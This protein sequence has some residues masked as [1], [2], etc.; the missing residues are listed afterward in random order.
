MPLNGPYPHMG[1]GLG[2]Q[3]FEQWNDN[4]CRIWQDI[5]SAL[6]DGL[7][8]IDV[9]ILAATLNRNPEVSA[10]LTDVS[11]NQYATL[12]RRLITLDYL[13]QKL[14]NFDDHSIDAGL[15]N[16]PV[17][18]SDE[19]AVINAQVAE[20]PLDDK[21]LLTNSAFALGTLVGWSNGSLDTS[22]T[23]RGYNTAQII[24]G[25]VFSQSVF[26]VTKPNT[27]YTLSC[28]A[29]YSGV[30]VS[31]ILG[32][33]FED[34]VTGKYSFLPTG[35]SDW[36]RYTFT[37]TTSSN[38]IRLNVGWYFHPIHTAGTVWATCF[39]LEKGNV[40]TDWSP[41]PED[42]LLDRLIRLALLP[43]DGGDWD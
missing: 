43:L 19:Q 37:F 29:K 39:K 11:G 4:L 25:G 22:T 20:M 5:S 36:A 42:Y 27:T 3:F 34:G 1:V 15:F 41:A 14:G 17:L 10:A 40:A 23:Y 33:Y 18:T 12:F 26:A 30:T 24:P 38:M 2:S 9:K 6:G 31:G 21:N 16:G 32:L 28:Y 8:T 7:D 35:D 13:R